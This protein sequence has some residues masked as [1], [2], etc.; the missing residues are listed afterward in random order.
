MLLSPLYCLEAESEY[1][2]GRVYSLIDGKY[3]S[4][5]GYVRI[6][7][8][9]KEG[10]LIQKTITGKDGMYYFQLEPGS[11]I[12]KVEKP[13]YIGRTAF[14][15]LKPESSVKIDFELERRVS[16]YDVT[17]VIDGLPEGLHPK[18]N[19]DGRFQGFAVNGSVYSFRG[20]TTHRIKLE[21]AIRAGDERYVIDGSPY[22]TFNSTGALKFKY[23]RQFYVRSA[24]SPDLAG[25]YHE[26]E[27]LITERRGDLI[28]PNGTRLIFEHWVKDGV[29]LE[30]NPAVVEVDSS[31][32]IEA[33]YRRQY[34]VQ[35]DPGKA[36]ATGGG[37][38][39][40]GSVAKVSISKLEIEEEELEYHFKGW[41]GDVETSNA[42]AVFPV[43]SP[44]LI[45]ADWEAVVP[46]QVEAIDPI[47]VAIISISL[48]I[49]VARILSGL[50][51]KFK[52]PEVLG[53]LFAGMLLSP[54]ALG[55]MRVAGF[56]IV[57]LNEYVLAF[58]EI[59]AILLLFIAG[60]EVSFGQFKA[61]GV[62]SAIVGA[63]G[64]IA[65]FFM[66]AYVSVLLGFDWNVGLIVGATLSATSIAIT[67][68]T[69]EEMGKLRSMEGSI[70]INSAV[71][72]D[73]LS[74][75]VLAMVMSII[76]LGVAPKPL[77]LILLL[78]KGIMFW[79][80]L[81][82]VVLVVGPRVISMAAKWKAKGT[83]E[84]ASTAM[85]FGGAIGAASVG[86]SPIVGAFSA[87]MALASSR[88]LPRIRDYID[89]LSMVFSPIFFAV[90][91]AAFNARA[92]NFNTVWIMAVLIAVA[93][94]SKLVGCGMPAS[95][96]LKDPRR[97]LRVGIG[98]IS[99]GEVGL[100]VAGIGMTSGIIAQDLYAA[101][102]TMVI[103]TTVIT[104]IM[105]KR[106]YA[107]EG[108]SAHA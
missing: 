52:I 46:V 101:I 79:F 42:T 62:K 28:L 16:P 26:G 37:W 106:S 73:V 108:A 45:Y 54:Y 21:E 29:A 98:M 81:M 89:K 7:V 35:V 20:G 48:L 97:G 104:P 22:V 24:S 1:V 11:Y 66:G 6:Y 33:K 74:L 56:Q 93:I 55:G 87:G 105:L 53:E 57:E 15:K 64:V 4:T 2:H 71:I 92:L 31:F 39:D 78:L 90:I 36:E 32:R 34:L 47:Y 65:P 69:L 61:V 23:L 94:V 3:Y 99:R 30:G 91:G 43:D 95:A 67:M 10:K 44:K 68:R 14:I 41:R 82:G 75:L 107:G 77:E 50:F 49:C 72:D 96:L 83:V 12:L 103:L 25:W 40:E 13:G 60:L 51:I 86:L 100:I 102:I 59:G 58:A 27:A 85:C 76:N 17:L 70:M 84:A 5:T 38:Y 18:I 80:L 8:Y 19:L 9:S 63:S 88:L